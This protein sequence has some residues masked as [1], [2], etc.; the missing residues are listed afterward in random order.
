[1]KHKPEEDTSMRMSGEVVSSDHK[2]IVG[3]K[4]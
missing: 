2:M 4:G 3:D 1:M